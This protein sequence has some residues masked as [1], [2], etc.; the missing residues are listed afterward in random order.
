MPGRT[1]EL[2]L[3]DGHYAA[4]I[5]VRGQAVLSSPTINRGTAFTYEERRELGLTGLLPTGVSTLD[6]QLRRT[7]AQYLEQSSNLGKWVYLANLHDRNEVLFY[8]LLSEHLEEMLP[9]VYTPTVGLA[10]ERFSHEYR[11][12]RGVHTDPDRAGLERRVDGNEAHPPG[13]TPRRS[14]GL[15]GRSGEAGSRCRA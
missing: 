12:P 5:N 1:H 8:K 3:S 6:G 9:V 14:R 11:R 2:V 15:P 7:Y 13:I 4:R 10:I